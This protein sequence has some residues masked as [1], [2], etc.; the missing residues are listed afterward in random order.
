MTS[1]VAFENVPG[2]PSVRLLL[3][4]AYVA[5]LPY[6]FEVTNGMNFA[7]ADCLLVLVLVLAAGQLIY[8]KQ[9]WAAWHFAIGLTF[10][11]GSLVAAVRFGK[12]DR[13]ELLN[14][15]AGLFLPFFSYAAITSAIVEWEDV[16]RILRV[17]S[18]SVVIQNAVA[19]A[20]YLASYFWGLPNPLARY[21]GLRLSGMLLDPNAYGGLLV[22][23]FV[24]VE[25]ADPGDLLPCFA[26][27][28]F[29]LSQ[30]DW[31]WESIH[32]LTLGMGGPGLGTAAA[33]SIEVPG[34]RPLGAGRVG[35]SA[36]RSPADGTAVRAHF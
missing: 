10:A 31:A 8:R 28:G 30:A 18:L 26:K 2:P 25:G 36:L 29:G 27:H 34:G 33:W 16:R 35:C 15:D 22:A 21:G 32:L 1:L 14:K 3:V 6:Q 20:A 13:Y 17:F 23:A 11:A 5:L 9:A 12:L 4:A 7:P 24:I 19:V